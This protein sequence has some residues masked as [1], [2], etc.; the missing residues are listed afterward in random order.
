MAPEAGAGRSMIE[1]VI[2]AIVTCRMEKMGM[3]MGNATA[4]KAVEEGGTEAG[5]RMACM[6]IEAA[7]VL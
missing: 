5:P 3:T 4:D 6:L 1:A 7:G 2:A